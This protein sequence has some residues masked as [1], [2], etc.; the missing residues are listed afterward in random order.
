M[1][2]NLRQKGLTKVVKIC[3][4]IMPDFVAKGAKGYQKGYYGVKTESR[5]MYAGFSQTGS[6]FSRSLQFARSD[7]GWSAAL[8]AELVQALWSGRPKASRCE[9]DKG[10][11]G[12]A[13]DG[14][15]AWRRE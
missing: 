1:P 7:V 6:G 15:C 12:E 11:H 4:K 5:Q 2:E 8:G 13:V 14:W 9:R 10:E 3:V